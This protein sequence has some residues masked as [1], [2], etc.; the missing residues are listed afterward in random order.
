LKLRATIEMVLHKRRADRERKAVLEGLAAAVDSIGEGVVCS[1]SA[2]VVTLM[3]PGVGGLDL[4]KS[5]NQPLIR[6][7]TSLVSISPSAVAPSAAVVEGTRTGT[8]ASADQ[9]APTSAY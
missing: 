8:Y 6:G 2:G 5:L 1:D 4:A 9:R 7:E 3:N